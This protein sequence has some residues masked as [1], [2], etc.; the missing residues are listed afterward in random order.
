M[1]R[2]APWSALLAGVLLVAGVACGSG[3]AGERAGEAGPSVDDTAEPQESWVHRRSDLMGFAQ[4]IS[5]SPFWATVDKGI[6]PDAATMAEDAVAVVRAEVTG[7]ETGPVIVS[8]WDRVL[9]ET[10]ER[11][12]AEMGPETPTVSGTAT[13]AIVA[14]VISPDSELIAAGSEVRVLAPVL[15]V[16]PGEYAPKPED[17]VVPLLDHEVVGLEVLVAVGEFGPGGELVPALGL[18]AVLM[19]L[20]DGS[21]AVVLSSPHDDGRIWGT[22]DLAALESAMQGN[23]VE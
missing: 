15:T 23:A 10:G 18:D 20:P 16:V 7:L 17:V 5:T 21:A 11:L 14:E 8:D 13:I 3:E 19:G 1:R 12:K 22:S 4:R 6:P 2:S 9:G